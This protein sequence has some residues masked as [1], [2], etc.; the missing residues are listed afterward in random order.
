MNA[1]VE[2]TDNIDLGVNVFNVLDRRHYQIFGGTMLGR[3]ATANLVFE[4]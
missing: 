3:Y 2:L 4:F 1:A